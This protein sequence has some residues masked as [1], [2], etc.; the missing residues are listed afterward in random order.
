MAKNKTVETEGSVADFINHISDEKKRADFSTILDLITKHT[1]LEP[2]MWGTSMVGFGSYHYKY[3]SGR[4][5]DAALV[6]IASRAN[7]ITFYLGAEADNTE[8]LLLKLG[9]HKMK[10][11]CLHIQQLEDIDANV[12]IKMVKNS[13]AHRRKQNQD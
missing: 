12:L 1:K 13:I 8:A 5:G 2:K 7:T 9:K 11:G 6:S 3:D 4:E 10:G